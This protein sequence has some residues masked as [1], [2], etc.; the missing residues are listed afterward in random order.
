MQNSIRYYI[1]RRRIAILVILLQLN[2]NNIIINLMFLA[3]MWIQPTVLLN[4]KV[5][6]STANSN[7]NIG[8]YHTNM[9]YT[10]YT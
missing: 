9:K 2:K 7:I 3:K 6:T 10:K 8:I 1:F 4:V 5:I